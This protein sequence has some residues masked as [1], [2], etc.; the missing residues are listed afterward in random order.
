MT[1]L[2]EMVGWE[3]TRVW[4]A[5]DRLRRIGVPLGLFCAFAVLNGVVFSPEF[6]RRG[7]WLFILLWVPL[8]ATVAP[9]ADS[10]AGERER[11]TLE[12]LLLSPVPDW[13]IVGG[14]LVA[15][16]IYALALIGVLFLSQIGV[17]VVSGSALPSLSWYGV[18]VG[19]AV[20]SHL[21]VVSLGLM[22]SWRAP[23][24]Q[25][26]QQ[27]LF[28]VL[29]LPALALFILPDQMAPFFFAPLDA[30][31]LRPAVAVGVVVGCGLATLAVLRFRRDRLLLRC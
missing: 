26:A 12:G 31:A 19:L 22:V 17:F 4:R 14:K 5:R 6:M 29:I 27:G 20:F 13:A 10:F 15:L 30:A 3:L 25:V 23:S 2:W 7:V 18:T 28:L 9:I 1:A 24:L 8:G 16:L 11:G 21:A